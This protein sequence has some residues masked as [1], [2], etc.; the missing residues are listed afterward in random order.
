MVLN[1]RPITSLYTEKDLIEPVTPKKRLFGRNFL[2]TS[3]EHFDDKTDETCL[4]KCCM[5][6]SILLHHFWN[7]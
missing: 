2:Y 5:R 4:T 1:N 3:T 6:T 7:R